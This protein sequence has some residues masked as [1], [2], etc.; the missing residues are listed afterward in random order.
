MLT[1]EGGSAPA[2]RNFRDVMTS[3]GATS[4]WVSAGAEMNRKYPMFR[5]PADAHG[6]LDVGASV[7]YADKCV[8]ALQVRQGPWGVRF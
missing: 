1:V 8:K 5:F 4:R 2:L 3:Q 6:L 7:L